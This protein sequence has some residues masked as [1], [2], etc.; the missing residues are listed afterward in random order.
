VRPVFAAGICALLLAAAC[1]GG[2]SSQ[3]VVTHPPESTS[4]SPG[5]GTGASPSPAG[6]NQA[7]AA[8]AK[9]CPKA[10]SRRPA[11]PGD[12]APASLLRI[13]GFVEEARGLTFT[14]DVNM[15]AVT[16]QRMRV[17]ISKEM[18][19]PGLDRYLTRR[20]RA[21]ETMGAVPPRTDLAAA[22]QDFTTSQVIGFY[23][24]ARKVLVF[25]GEHLGAFEEFTLAHE[26]VHAL[27]DQRF[28][29]DRLLALDEKCHDEA[30][31]AARGL[32][33]GSATVYSL[34]VVQ[35]SFT[36]AEAG[37]LAKSA[38]T[39]D[40]EVPDSVPEFLLKGEEWPYLTG[41]AFVNALRDKGGDALVDYAFRHLPATSEQVMHPDR[42]PD[43]A[44]QE[45]DVPDALGPPAWET[46]DVGEVGEAWLKTY[47]EV[48]G[49]SDAAEAAAGWDGGIYRAWGSPDGSDTAV[50]METVWDTPKDATDFAAAMEEA[51]VD[52]PAAE[53]SANGD[54]VTVRFG[55]SQGSL[56][57]L[58][59]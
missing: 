43:D 5:T 46:I 30:G 23:D 21:W 19:S 59:P 40:A 12:P 15:E 11:P 16:P 10:P 29:L 55:S 37:D 8:A 1:S 39:M 28:G 58:T 41:M 33:E 3:Q 31:L 44:P 6:R 26:L 34:K 20:G 14:H 50:V 38:L 47:L 22:Y 45:L 48:R 36:A 24:P 2:T 54:R 27:E 13:E 57:A 56:A 18:A 7:L 49:V 42:Y 51:T 4:A 25:I 35:D 32:A 9:L 53:V 52:L 17:L